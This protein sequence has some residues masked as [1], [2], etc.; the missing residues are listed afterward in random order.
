MGGYK[1]D[2]TYSKAQSFKAAANQKTYWQKKDVSER[3][4]ATWYLI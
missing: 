1:L 4:E 2:K 3:L